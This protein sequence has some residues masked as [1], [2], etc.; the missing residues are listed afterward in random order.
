[1]ART[2]AF[3]R[4]RRCAWDRGPGLFAGRGQT[5]DDETDTFYLL[6]PAWTPVLGEPLNLTNYP[7]LLV[8]DKRCC[9]ILMRFGFFIDTFLSPFSLPPRL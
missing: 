9:S 3:P 7:F 1:M 4:T 2:L 5:F 6:P 8:V